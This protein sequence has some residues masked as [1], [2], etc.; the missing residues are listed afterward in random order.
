M[1]LIDCIILTFGALYMLF[2]LYVAWVFRK[3]MPT[4][5]RAALREAAIGAAVLAAGT[6]AY[7]LGALQ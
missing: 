3:D 1:S 7:L 5:T 6:I 2:N 4:V